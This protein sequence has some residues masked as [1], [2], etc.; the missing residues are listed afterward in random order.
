[1]FFEDNNVIYHV[2]INIGNSKMIHSPNSRSVV[3][4]DLF[5]AGVYGDKYW[6]ARRY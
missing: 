1:M 4:E 5:D 2:G 6:G 3:R